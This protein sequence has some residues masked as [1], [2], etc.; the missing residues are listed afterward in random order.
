MK[1]ILINGL[2]AHS[3]GGPLFLNNYL[4]I[5]NNSNSSRKYYV[6]PPKNFEHQKFSSEIIE[7]VDIKKVFKKRELIP[8]TY[9]YYLPQ[10]IK[11][12]EIDVIFNLADI[13]IPTKNVKQV[14]LFDWIF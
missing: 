11:S 2:S 4:T 5:L 13:P 8:I 14:F 1:R 10:L 9:K 6:L 3:G 7:I 12:L